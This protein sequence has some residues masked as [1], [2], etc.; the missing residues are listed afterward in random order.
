MPALIRIRALNG[1][2]ATVRRLGGDPAPFLARVGL[3]AADLQDPSRWI[4]LKGFLRLLDLA[5]RG[6]DEPAFGV[7]LARGRDLAYLGPLLLMAQHS[8]DVGAAL[9][10]ISRYIGFQNTSHRTAFDIGPQT[11]IRS[12]E[13]PRDLRR[14][15]DQ[16][17]EASLVSTQRLVSHLIG[18]DAPVLWYS[19]RHAPLRP[20][21]RY[22]A[23]LGVPIRFEQDLDGAVFD[24][25]LAARRIPNR[26]PNLQKFVMDYLD[27]RF[28]PAEHEVVSATRNLIEALIPSGRAKVETV[29]ERLALHPRTLQRRLTEHGLSFS[30]LLEEQRK[31][32]AER[33]LRE[34]NLPLG[35]VADF[36]GYAEQSA[37][38]HAFERWHGVAPSR[39]ARG[40]R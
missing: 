28:V 30:R 26:D 29:A 38:N 21:E 19:V 22:T 34:G 25:D 20:L 1:F 13:M 33:L 36:L 8:E 18:E 3:R 27:E 7:A 10:N 9:H 4:T 23:E 14:L 32:M 12:F 2:E 17:I 40:D 6:L 31:A 39:W 15:G 35:N 11:C 5:S 16:F 37:F 24:R